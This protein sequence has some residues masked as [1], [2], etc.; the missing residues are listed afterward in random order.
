MKLFTDILAVY[1]LG[2]FA[3]FGL[4]YGLTSKNL[5]QGNIGGMY[6]AS[7]IWPISLIVFIGML[8]WTLFT[9]KKW[10]K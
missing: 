10:T 4:I 1:I 3:F 6:I 5:R 2:T 9:G 8:I 7:A